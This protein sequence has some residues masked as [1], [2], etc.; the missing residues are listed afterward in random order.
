VRTPRLP[1]IANGAGDLTAALFLAYYLR[2][3]DA[4]AALGETAAAVHG[5]IAETARAGAAELQ[6]V[7]AQEA[8][9]APP[10]RY[11]VERAF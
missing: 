8:L 7:A 4:G 1:I 5:V 2:T 9:T 11:P 6:I 10:Q 3:K